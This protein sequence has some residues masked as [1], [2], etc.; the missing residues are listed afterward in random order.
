MSDLSNVGDSRTLKTLLTI[1]DLG[2]GVVP[3]GKVETW[4]GKTDEPLPLLMLAADGYIKLE[5]GGASITRRGTD[6]VL[7]MREYLV[8]LMNQNS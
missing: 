3:R 7:R 4:V 8:K 1:H 5:E 6:T 2:P